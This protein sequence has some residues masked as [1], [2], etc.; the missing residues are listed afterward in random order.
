MDAICGY[1]SSSSSSS[2]DE[3]TK[4]VKFN[5]VITAN[6]NVSNA[7]DENDDDEEEMGLQ[8]RDKRVKLNNGK[9]RKKFNITLPTLNDDFTLCA[10]PQQPVATAHERAEAKY[11]PME[12]VPESRGASAQSQKKVEGEG[13]HKKGLLVPPQIWKKKPN[14]TSL[15]A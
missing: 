2:E 7:A 1:G 8:H 11:M 5:R 12:V 3:G 6:V 10:V 9:E 14:V 13:A 4:E 15:D